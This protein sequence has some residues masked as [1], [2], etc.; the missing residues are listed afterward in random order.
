MNNDLELQRLLGLPAGEARGQLQARLETLAAQAEGNG[1]AA[2]L[3]DSLHDLEP[4]DERLRDAL[5]AIDEREGRRLLERVGTSPAQVAERIAGRVKSHAF[6]IPRAHLRKREFDPQQECGENRWLNWWRDFSERVLL[7]LLGPQP[8]SGHLG[9]QPGWTPVEIE[10]LDWPGGPRVLAGSCKTPEFGGWD[11]QRTL[12]VTL[13]V[14]DIDLPSDRA[15]SFLMAS[16][17]DDEEARVMVLV[18]PALRREVN[19]AMV[20]SG[21]FEQPIAD[22]GAVTNKECLDPG[23]WIFLL[24]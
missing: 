10:V 4:D 17:S 18:A 6:L 24:K 1:P 21:R 9:G 7:G 8:A 14:S 13:H 20:L 3:L 16:C 12:S 15:W 23:R 19:G 5:E 11:D 2:L 22:E